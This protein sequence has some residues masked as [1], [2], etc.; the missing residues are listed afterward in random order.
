MMAYIK[1]FHNY[2][3]IGGLFPDTYLGLREITV[4]DCIWEAIL[5]VVCIVAEILE[6]DEEAVLKQVI[7]DSR[8]MA[9]LNQLAQTA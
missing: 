4:I 9:L 5:E 3:T 6:Y 1:R 2:E 8:R 7:A